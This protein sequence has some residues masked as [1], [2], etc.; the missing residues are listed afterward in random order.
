VLRHQRR[1]LGQGEHEDEVEEQ[2][3]RRDPLL[4]LVQLTL[5]NRRALGDAHRGV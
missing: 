1:H 2:L 5:L 3:E 4:A